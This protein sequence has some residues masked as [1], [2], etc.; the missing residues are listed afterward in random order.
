M[1]KIFTEQTSNSW[2]RQESKLNKKS[3]TTGQSSNYA[4][5]SIVIKIVKIEKK[6]DFSFFNNVKTLRM[7]VYFSW[8]VEKTKV[9]VTVN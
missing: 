5:K 4:L 3:H 7:L 9:A 1:N 8:N 2:L 6:N